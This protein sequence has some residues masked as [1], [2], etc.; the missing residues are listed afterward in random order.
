MTRPPAA[1]LVTQST[2]STLRIRV[3]ENT[4][5]ILRE[6]AHVVLELLA[7]TA[8]VGEIL[9]LEFTKPHTIGDTPAATTIQAADLDAFETLAAS[10]IL[11]GAA[12]RYAQNTGS[13]NLPG[14]LVDRRTQSDVM[15]S[16]AKS[17]RNLYYQ[18]VGISTGTNGAGSAGVAPASA[19]KDLDVGTSHRGG[20][21]WHGSR[22]H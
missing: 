21:L 20:L 16:R 5:R 13:S 19:I 18:M 17:L 12:I 10:V 22:A 2:E 1:G 15:S 4:Y 11:E 14:D 7:D 8:A 6:P 3:D 9:R